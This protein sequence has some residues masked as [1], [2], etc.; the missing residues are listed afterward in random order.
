VILDRL[1]A[2]GVGLALDDFGT[3]YAS[4]G[5]LNQLRFDKPRIDRCFVDGIEHDGKKRGLLRGILAL[6]EGLGLVTIA[7]GAERAG[8][9]ELLRGMGCAI[10]QGF[11]FARPM[12]AAEA[13]A[14]AQARESEAAQR[15]A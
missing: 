14:F 12:P 7:E 4:L 2:F 6:G 15:A 8:E 13:A 9:V 5:C 11:A 1:A 3:G 10:A